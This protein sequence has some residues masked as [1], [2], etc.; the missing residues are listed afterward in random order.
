MGKL[1]VVGI[2][3]QQIVVTPDK[4]VTYAL[5]SC[6]GICI[7]DNKMRV[8]GL[9]HILLPEAFKDVGKNDVFKFANT[10]IE[11]MVHAMERLGCNRFQLS[12]K[13]A[14][15]ANMF[16]TQGKSIGERN[17]EVVK[18]ELY[19]LR[20]R[21]VAEDIGLNYGRTIEFNSEDGTM[22]VK[23]AGRGNKIF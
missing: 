21:I 11:T 15:G 5:G 8:G 16:V 1:V 18:R 12:A 7:Y 17:V 10:A 6:V 9:S 14:G 2:S 23:T 19:R 20:I 13:I 4:L 22:I 3:D